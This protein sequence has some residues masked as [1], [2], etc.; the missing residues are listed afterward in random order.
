M[1]TRAE[2]DFVDHLV[3][4]RVLHPDE[5]L[6]AAQVQRQ[7]LVLLDE[8]FADQAERRLAQ[9]EGADVDQGNAVFLGGG[10]GEEVRFRC[11]GLDQPG[12]KRL[13]FPGGFGIRGFGRPGVEDILRDQAAR[14]SVQIAGDL[15]LSVHQRVAPFPRKIIP[16]YYLKYAS[17]CTVKIIPAGNRVTG[18]RRGFAA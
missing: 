14:Q 15:E 9:V 1:K 17:P 13:V 18:V 10:G 7:N 8:G 12:Q 4:R 16:V 11:A 2:G 3:I 5:K 6:V